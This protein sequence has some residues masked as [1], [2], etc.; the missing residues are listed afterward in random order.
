MITSIIAAIVIGAI[1][2]VL[3]RLALPGKQNISLVLTI[4]VGIVAA[5]IGTAIARAIGVE[6]TNG[7]DWVEHLIQIILA[8]VGV[9]I[10]AGATGR[11]TNRVH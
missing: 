11:N 3:G 10:V 9:A 7:I 4:A 2:G 1:I 6:N 8:A 5:L